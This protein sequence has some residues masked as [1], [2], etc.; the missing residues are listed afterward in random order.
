MFD[1]FFFLAEYQIMGGDVSLS[2]L[3]LS[4]YILFLRS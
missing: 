4:D 3:F 2:N 1:F